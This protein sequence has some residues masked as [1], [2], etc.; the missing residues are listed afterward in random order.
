MNSSVVMRLDT[1]LEFRAVALV[2][3]KSERTKNKVKFMYHRMLMDEPGY[4]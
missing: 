4:I 2:D 3:V 1:R